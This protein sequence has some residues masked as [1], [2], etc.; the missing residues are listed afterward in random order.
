M[1]PTEQ[2]YPGF[3]FA[4]EQTTNCSAVRFTSALYCP[5]INSSGNME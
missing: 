5:L 3:P 4:V 1:P 2:L